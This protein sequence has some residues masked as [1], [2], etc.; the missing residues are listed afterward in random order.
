MDIGTV[1]INTKRLKLRKISLY[2]VQSIYTHLKADERVTDNLIK[3]IHKSS[4]ET[5]VMVEEIISQYED[6]SFY[7]W[8][9]E[10]IESKEL[11]G[12]IDL[13]EFE[14]DER[15]CKVG[16]LIGH[17]WWNKGYGTEALRAVVD[18]AFNNIKVSEISAAHNTDNPA[19]GRIMEKVGMQKHSIV[20]DM[21]TNA[22]GQS[23][24][25]AIYKLKNNN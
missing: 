22:K 23:K 17:N 25:C 1:T 19:S 13:F 5:L 12:L 14:Y 20:K 15:K 18:F 4:E 7:Y 9:I 3:G 2:D 6:P 21:I 24:D 8:G 11:I 10:L 16:Y